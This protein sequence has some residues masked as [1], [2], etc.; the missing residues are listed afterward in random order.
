VIASNNYPNTPPPTS[1]DGWTNYYN[2]EVEEKTLPGDQ[3]MFDFME[4]LKH[5]KRRNTKP[6][7][8]HVKLK[9]RRRIANASKKKN[10]RK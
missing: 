6:K 2:Q 10:R 9:K 3:E 5:R 1:G 7:R 8:N 4:W